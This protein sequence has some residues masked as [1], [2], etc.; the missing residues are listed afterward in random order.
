VPAPQ[1]KYARRVYREFAAPHDLTSLV[2]CTWEAH[3]TVERS[4][5][6]VPDACLDILWT[7]ARLT[8]AGPDT[9]TM[10]AQSAAGQHYRALRLRSGSA[11]AVLGL[12]AS[13]LCDA[14]VEL[15]DVWGARAR[16]LEDAL[17]AARDRDAQRAL[18]LSAVAE[19]M[20][21]VRPDRLALALVERL[22]QRRTPEPR[23]GAL[24]DELGVSER[25]LHRRCTEAIGYGPKLLARILRLHAFKR[26]LRAAPQ[27]SIAELACAL[28][29]ADQAHLTHDARQ[30][31]DT[32]PA[33]MRS[34]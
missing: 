6:V 32:T 14:R 2:A 17:V 29:Y 7:G 13:A 34:E 19:R 20:G 18:L 16:T 12:P 33:Q 27:A 4:I 22:Q 8:I 10:V 24:A 1:H 5:R 25:Q 3:S 21:A 28:G 26:A 11:S 23:I 31:F 15:S 30:L 9:R